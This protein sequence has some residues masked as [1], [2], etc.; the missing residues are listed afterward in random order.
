MLPIGNPDDGTGRPQVPAP[1]SATSSGRR[2]GSGYGAN[3]ASITRRLR[4]RRRSS[5][6][7]PMRRA[8][9]CAS[10]RAVRR[11]AAR[12]RPCSTRVGP[13]PIL[14]FSR[15]QSKDEAR[16]IVASVAKAVGARIKQQSRQRYGAALSGFAFVPKPRQ[17]P[18]RHSAGLRTGSEGRTIPPH[19]RPVCDQERFHS[20]RERI[21]PRTQPSTRSSRLIHR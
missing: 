20:D 11:A 19:S 15:F 13:T 2:P 16:R 4:V 10:A 12:A 3:A 8:T 21:A 6:G 14:A 7:E 1:R 18:L 17:S 9:C 5:A